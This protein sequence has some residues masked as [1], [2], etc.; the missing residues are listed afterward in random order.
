MSNTCNFK[1]NSHITGVC[2]YNKLT[3]VTGINKKREHLNKYL[4]M[5]V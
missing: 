3:N 2:T 1:L 4:G 5:C